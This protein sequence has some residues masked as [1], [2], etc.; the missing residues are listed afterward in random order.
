[1]K[2]VD[3]MKNLYQHVIIPGMKDSSNLTSQ[4]GLS[5]CLAPQHHAFHPHP[6]ALLPIHNTGIMHHV[7]FASQQLAQVE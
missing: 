3:G 7:C 1:M 2:L 4:V 5:I 6:T